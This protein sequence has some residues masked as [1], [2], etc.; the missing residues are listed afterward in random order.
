[1]EPA[2]GGVIKILFKMISFSNITP[3]V[4]E[5]IASLCG[6]SICLDG[7]TN[8]CLPTGTTGLVVALKS[9]SVFWI[10]V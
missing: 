2:P 5:S 6:C 1:M 8:Y 3:S 10:R 9:S 7:T 4:V